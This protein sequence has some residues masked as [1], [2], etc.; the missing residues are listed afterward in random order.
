VFPLQDVLGLDTRHRMNTPGLGEG[1]WSW[2]FD[3]SMVGT[4]P[5]RVLGAISAVTGRVN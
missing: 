4:E 1:N 3:W 5:A 2:R